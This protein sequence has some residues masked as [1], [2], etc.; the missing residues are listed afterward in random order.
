MVTKKPPRPNRRTM[1]DGSGRNPAESYA[2]DAERISDLMARVTEVGEMLRT[3]HEMIEEVAALLNK[4]QPPLPGKIELRW[5]SSAGKLPPVPTVVLWTPKGVDRIEPT[6]LR[7][8]AASR[9]GFARNHDETVYLLGILE[10][11]M[12]YRGKLLKYIADFKKAT[13]YFKSFHHKSVTDALNA[14]ILEKIETQIDA[15]NLD[16]R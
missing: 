8:R 14:R 4:S 10:D 13:G 15:K 6:G 12:D 1:K 7:K 9:S 11:L 2:A 16:I 5:W 3:N